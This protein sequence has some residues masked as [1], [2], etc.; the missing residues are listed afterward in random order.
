MVQD[1]GQIVWGHITDGAVAGT[2]DG[3]GSDH[4]PDRD[5]A[6]DKKLPFFFNGKDFFS[7]SGNPEYPF[8]RIPS[9]YTTLYNRISYK[10]L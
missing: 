4:I 3:T 2:G 5:M 10:S 9:P 6:A 7:P 1:H 8:R